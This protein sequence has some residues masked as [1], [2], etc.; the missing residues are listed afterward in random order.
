DPAGGEDGWT[1]A[2]LPWQADGFQ[3][4][5]AERPLPTAPEDPFAACG[6]GSAAPYEDAV[7]AVLAA[8]AKVLASRLESRE[9]AR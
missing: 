2:P 5:P 9:E 3:D 4:D 6:Q 8:A 1:W 7:A